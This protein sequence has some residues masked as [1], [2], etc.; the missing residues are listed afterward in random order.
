MRASSLLLLAYTLLVLAAAAIA[1]GDNLTSLDGVESPAPVNTAEDA[2]GE[3]RD[4]GEIVQ[5]GAAIVV[6]LTGLVAF[7]KWF[8][9]NRHKK[10]PKFHPQLQSLLQ[11]SSNSRQSRPFL[12]RNPRV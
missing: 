7:F 2:R 4:W 6:I 3:G 9:N 1:D 5:F 10:M 11:S 8:Y 12:Y